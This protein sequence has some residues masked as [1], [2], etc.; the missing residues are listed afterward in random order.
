M[1]EFWRNRRVF[2]TGHTGFKGAWLN[3]WL[4]TLGAKVTG[5]ALA[6]PT[7]PN[8]FPIVE[9]RAHSHMP[10]IRAGT[11]VP[12]AFTGA[13]PQIAIPMPPPPLFPPPH[14]PPPPP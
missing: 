12:H 13:H 9:S 10:D 11:N 6:A 5:Y 7:E 14:P 3:L 8:M 2:L 4:Q 1:G